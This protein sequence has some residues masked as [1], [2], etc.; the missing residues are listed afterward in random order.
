MKAL[1]DSLIILIIVGLVSFTCKDD[2]DAL[3]VAAI[4][5][6]L[7]NDFFPDKKSK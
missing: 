7:M 1:R 3:A 2:V 5:V 6:I 4:T